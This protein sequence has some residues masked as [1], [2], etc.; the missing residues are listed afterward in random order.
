MA[1]RRTGRG[2]DCERQIFDDGALTMA[3]ANAMAPNAA[4]ANRCSRSRWR[5]SGSFDGVGLKAWF[6]ELVTSSRV[7]VQN[8]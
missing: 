5:W 8:G 1:S 2:A 4:P 6:G 3:S 7:S